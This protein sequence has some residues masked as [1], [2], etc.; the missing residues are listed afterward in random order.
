[1][2]KV[3][4]SVINDLVTDQR[5]NKVAQTLSNNGYSVLLLG[6]LLPKSM[7]IKR[8]YQTK[9]M[10][11]LF[12]KGVLFYIEMNIRIFLFLLF[13]KFDIALSNDLDTLL[14]NY[15]VTTLKRKKLVY[16]SH[17]IF[18]EVPEV[19]NRKFIK[20]FWE[21]LEKFLIH[22]IKFAYTVNASVSEY[23]YNKYGIKM[24]IVRNV[25]YLSNKSSEI[26]SIDNFKTFR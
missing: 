21:K 13:H 14:P 12:K 10:T 15:L 3:I 9:R 6:R 20:T 5:V 23:Y 2:K 26:I 4:I 16:D 22:R 25:P 18:P 1:M 7:P 24:Q 19:I 17:E 8:A 11:L